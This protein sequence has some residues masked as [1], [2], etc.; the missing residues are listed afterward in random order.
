LASILIT[1]ALLAS[2]G[3]D[4]C[5]QASD[6]VQACIDKIDCRKTDPLEKQSCEQR[7]K[8]LQQSAGLPDVACTGD[9]KTR[10][11]QIMLCDLNPQTC[12]C[13]R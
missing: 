1:V 4:V 12:E 10:A 7:K 2:C 6:K 8:A 5:R 13:P 11:D 3:S 9:I